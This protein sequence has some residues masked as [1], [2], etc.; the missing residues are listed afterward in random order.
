M[1]AREAEIHR[2]G[3]LAFAGFSLEIFIVTAIG[4][5]AARPALRGS[6]A[7]N[8]R[9]QQEVLDK[10]HLAA[11]LETSRDPALAADQAKSIFLATM[12][13]EIRTPMN[14]ASGMLELVRA[15]Y[16]QAFAKANA[17]RSRISLSRLTSLTSLTS[18][19]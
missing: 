7:A 2:H 17:Q 1:T 4:T 18:L 16:W 14:G 13:H 15:A 6:A 10:S 9:L 19:L 8:A 5:A 12:S 3:N 11:Q